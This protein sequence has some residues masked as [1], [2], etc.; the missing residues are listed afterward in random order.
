MLLNAI[1]E[2]NT[3]TVSG[4][5]ESVHVSPQ[6]DD[7]NLHV[8]TQQENRLCIGHLIQMDLRFLMG[9]QKK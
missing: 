7:V 8:K 2:G 1:G 9:Y 6:L 3:P 4:I 5:R